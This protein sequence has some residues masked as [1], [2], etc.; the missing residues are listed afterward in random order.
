MINWLNTKINAKINFH[1]KGIDLYK[2][3]GAC[4]LVLCLLLGKVDSCSDDRNV[5][6]NDENVPR[7]SRKSWL[8]LVMFLI[9]ILATGIMLINL[10]IAIFRFVMA[11]Q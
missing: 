1:H 10:L 11:A 8:A 6:L 9:Y 7:C 2:T 5:Y 3:Y 4:R